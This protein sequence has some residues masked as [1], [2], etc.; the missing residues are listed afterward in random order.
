MQGTEVLQFLYWWE[1]EYPGVPSIK[2]LGYP[3]LAENLG[4]YRF[5]VGPPGLPKDIRDILISAFKKSFSDKEFQAWTK[6]S[7][8]DLDPLYG[9]DA[10]QLAKKMVKYY[11]QDLKPMLKKYLDK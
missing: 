8:F 6:K 4:G 9:N 1:S 2:D 7:N 3:Q 11:Q 5:I 10:D